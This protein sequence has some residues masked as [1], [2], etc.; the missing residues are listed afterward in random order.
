[1]TTSTKVLVQLKTVY[2]DDEMWNTSLEDMLSYDSGIVVEEDKRAGKILV[3]LTRC[4]I[5]RWESFGFRV[6]IMNRDTVDSW[7]IKGFTKT[8]IVE[9]KRAAKEYEY[10]ESDDKNET[11]DTN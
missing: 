6:T 2:I 8:E 3:E 4:T 1:M 10:T 7:S 9:M 5:A 11:H